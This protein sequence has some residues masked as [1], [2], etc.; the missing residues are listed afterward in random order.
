MVSI[1]ALI[2]LVMGLCMG[3][4]KPKTI[5]LLY[6]L[7]LCETCSIKGYGHKLVGSETVCTRV[8]RHVHLHT[9]VLHELTL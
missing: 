8:A 1:L 5:K 9:V 7:P 6:V 3:P 4:V 2:V